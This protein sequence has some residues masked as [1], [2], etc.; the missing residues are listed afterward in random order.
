MQDPDELWTIFKVACIQEGVQMKNG[1]VVALCEWMKAKGDQVLDNDPKNA[2]L[3]I[4]V[5]QA[6]EYQKQ[7]GLERE[8]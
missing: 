1:A 2:P 4:L 6:R 5:E 3:Y 8:G 7:L